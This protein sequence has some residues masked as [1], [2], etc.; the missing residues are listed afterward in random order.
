MAEKELPPIR[1]R[2][3]GD[4]SNFKKVLNNLS[5]NMNKLTGSAPQMAEAA[6]SAVKLANAIN[7]INMGLLVSHGKE[8]RKVLKDLSTV[9]LTELHN[10]V[11]KIAKKFDKILDVYNVLKK[12]SVD[13][14]FGGGTGF[15]G[16]L[17][18]VLNSIRALFSKSLPSTGGMAS[19]AAPKMRGA[20]AAPPGS[21]QYIKAISEGIGIQTKANAEA[22]AKTTKA[23]ADAAKTT[24]KAN[25]DATAK[26]TKAAADAAA[27]T[28]KAAADAAAKTT[29]AAADAAKIT[30]K[31]N[32]DAYATRTKADAD[33]V[34]KT[35]KAAA[36][37]A[38]TQV[39]GAARA[40]A[41]THTAMVT[42]PARAAA[43]QTNAAATAAATQT[44]AAA[45]AA[46]TQ[47]RSDEAAAT[48]QQ[49]RLQAEDMHQLNYRRIRWGMQRAEEAHRQKMRIEDEIHQKRMKSRYYTTHPKS[50]GSS[51]FGGGGLG[52]GLTSR[53]DIYMHANALRTLI[54][55]GQGVL[56]LYGNLKMAEAGLQAF[57]GSAQSSATIMAEIKD[58][59]EKTSFTRLGLTE[60]TRNMMSYGLSAKS[61]LEHMKMLG[62]V[63]GGSELRFER[64]SFAMSQI[65]ANGRLQGNELRQLTEQGF[66]PLE[67]M[68]RVTG[69]SMLELRKMMEDG[70]ISADHVT[71]A[72]KMETSAGGRFAN[73]QKQMANTL[74]GLRNQLKETVQ[75]LKIGFVAALEKDLVRAMKAVIGYLKLFEMYLQTPAGKQMADKMVNIAKNVFVAAVAF[76]AIGF[77]M[78]SLMWWSQSVFSMLS[79]IVFVFR[80]LATGISILVSI[81]TSPFALIVAGAIAAGLAVAYVASQIWGPNSVY[82]AFLNLYNTAMW[83][84]N[85]VSGFLYNFGHNW[86]VISKWLMD[87]WAT[88]IPDM[89]EL[90]VRFFSAMIS[91]AQVGFRT[92]ARLMVVFTTWLADTWYSLFD[93]RVY[94]AMVSGFIKIFTWLE[95]KWKQF[96]TFMSKIWENLFDPGALY[97]V[98]S[99]GMGID[100]TA[101]AM[102]QDIQTTLDKGLFEGIKGVI[103]SEYKNLSTGLEGFQAST[104]ALT[105]LKF[106]IPSMP[107]PPKAPQL[108]DA[109]AYTGPGFA[110]LG[111]GG[112][113]D[114]KVTEA[115]AATGSDYSKLLAEQAGRMATPKA[116]PQLAAQQQTNNI[117]NMIYNALKN[118][119]QVNL[120]PAGV[121]GQGANP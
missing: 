93:G 37:A 52:G 15:L 69:K 103:E 102:T 110:G 74:P 79:R 51:M 9:K 61:A 7:G 25:A 54:S 40:A 97:D 98:I 59:A 47:R 105:G 106:D 63:A 10:E 31:A 115:M 86:S 30:T 14:K 95:D 71:E 20:T 58:H 60:A 4:D 19:Q 83:F 73:M 35:T 111:A 101:E 5:K 36:T 50:A 48:A 26:T 6:N 57:T 16:N 33:S 91:N 77:A 107:P 67:T 41:I 55:S 56:D 8:L 76:H 113:K 114:Y 21:A 53:A 90:T 112:A 100:A 108:A 87:N 117:L 64:L 1:V 39:Q 82:D 70:A 119:P 3:I 11:S 44:R 109:G 80:A 99:Q 94:E 65:T 104:P 118:A 66:N 23:A 22:A 68:S 89:M 38:A 32:A 34:A 121:A 24:T 84:F 29:K 78:A 28:T 27:V 116:N 92:V 120:Q 49:R 96:G 42:A 18:G 45:S 88:I 17:L 72:L 46:A 13:I 81:A 75:N 43:I 12:G 62:D 2:I 85:S